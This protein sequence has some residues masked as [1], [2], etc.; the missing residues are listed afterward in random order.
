M[1]M[2][3]ERFADLLTGLIEKYANKID[4]DSLLDP[5]RPTVEKIVGFFTVFI[6][7]LHWQYT[8]TIAFYRLSAG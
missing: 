4:L 7:Y 5:P 2:D 1:D 3:L 8:P 6:H